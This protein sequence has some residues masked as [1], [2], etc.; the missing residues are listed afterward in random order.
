MMREKEEEKGRG[1]ALPFASVITRRVDYLLRIGRT[2]YVESNGGN[3]R[4]DLS[5]FEFV[6]NRR[7]RH[8]DNGYKKRY[9]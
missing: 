2:G 1:R 4:Y 6:K 9:S 8:K 5:E 3:G 7:L